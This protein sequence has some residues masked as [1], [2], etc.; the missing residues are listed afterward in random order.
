VRYNRRRVP[1]P[2]LSRRE[3]LAVGAAAAAGA[4]APTPPQGRPAEPPSTP[5]RAVGPQ[6]LPRWRGFNLHEKLTMG[7]DEPY[8]EWDF[9]R[10]AE[11]GFDFV[12]LPTDYRIWT[13]SPGSYREPPLRE[14][15][16]AIAWGRERRIH[17]CLCLHRAPGYCVGAISPPEPLDLWADGADGDEARRR[18]AAQWRMLAERYRGID[19]AELSF[20]L[21]NEPP[22]ITGAQYVRAARAAVDAIRAADPRRLVI[23]DGASWGREPVADLVPLGVAQSTRGYAP[24]QLSTYKA[25]WMEESSTW[26]EPVWPIPPSLNRYVYGPWQ[27]E[28]ARPLVLRGDF[29]PGPIAVTV[30][31]VSVK[32]TLVV[33]AD[34]VEVLRHA[35]ETGP[36]AGAWK[37][38]RYDARLRIYQA[39]YDQRFAG[40]LTKGAREIRVEVVDGDWLT[41]S[42]LEVGGHTLVARDVAWG[43][44]QG[45]HSIDAKGALHPDAGLMRLDGAS[46]FTEHVEPWARFARDARVGVHV[47]EW[48]AYHHTPHA[49]TLAWMRDCLGSFRRAAFGWG[50]WNLRGA[51][52][53]AD[54]DRDD[55]SY[56][57]YKGHRLDRRMLELLKEDLSA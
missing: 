31:L 27:P 6:H 3:L 9:D 28:L 51:F 43:V 5:E 1:S 11:W 30:G 40:E 54:S 45:E 18:L 37:D 57:P 12:R 2:R 52:G 44:V 13:S 24:F 8:L 34:G 16:Q 38:S 42:K 21:V 19:P 56:E 20:N 53:V 14:I 39:T 4:C 35:F 23:A 25:S 22:R 36:G 49:V 55:V 15:D 32:A 48:G 10:I 46:L 29:A 7:M 17:V 47:G 41:F 26:P 33:L 50:L